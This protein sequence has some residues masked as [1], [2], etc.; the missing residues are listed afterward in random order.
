M[1]VIEV[2]IYWYIDPDTGK[3]VIDE[4]EMRAEF[5][6]RMQEL[7]DSNQDE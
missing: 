7:L 3:K 5:E 2:E 6:L 4:D 1:D